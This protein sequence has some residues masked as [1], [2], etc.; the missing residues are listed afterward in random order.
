MCKS[1]R[2]H[3]TRGGASR[4]Q[5]ES[6]LWCSCVVTRTFKR[7]ARFCESPPAV[8]V[9]TQLGIPSGSNRRRTSCFVG[10]FGSEPK[11]GGLGEAGPCEKLSILTGPAGRSPVR[12]SSR[13]R[14]RYREPILRTGGGSGG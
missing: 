4:R 6:K 3:V 11:V 14:T 9:K 8:A 10:I 13:A 1:A 7:A 2:E 5:A 12:N